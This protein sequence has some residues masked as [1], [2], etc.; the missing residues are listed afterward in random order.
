MYIYIYICEYIHIYVYVCIYIIQSIYI[1]IYIIQSIYACTNVY[2]SSYR[3][4]MHV[5][6]T[7]I[8]TPCHALSQS[9]FHLHVCIHL[10]TEC[11]FV[12]R[13]HIHVLFRRTCSPC[14]ASLQPSH[15]HMCIH[16]YTE[17]VYTYI[18]NNIYAPSTRTCSPC[19]A[20]SRSSKSVT[21]CFTKCR[22]PIP[23][24][25][26]EFSIHEHAVHLCIDIHVY[27]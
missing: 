13:M 15:V 17:Y 5:L 2:T 4:Y 1:Y 7:R 9:C 3:V 10:Y 23:G 19:L 21:S 16:V 18:Q 25:R 27:I 12:L 14:L 20:S 11:T 6:S 22:T 24:F 8:C 26:P